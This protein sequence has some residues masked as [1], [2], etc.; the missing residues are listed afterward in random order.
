M[1]IKGTRDGPPT[2][3]AL[4]SVPSS[5]SPGLGE[6]GT[7]LTPAALLHNVAACLRQNRTPLCEEWAGRIAGARVL[8]AMSP[9]ELR[10]E[11]GAIYDSSVEVLETGSMEV[12]QAQIWDL[13]E[14]ITRQG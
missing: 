9:E 6:S 1:K 13:S 11:T 8:S 7:D 10:S 12:L 3:W 5:A 2:R 14:R 4:I